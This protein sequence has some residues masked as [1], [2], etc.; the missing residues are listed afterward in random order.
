MPTVRERAAP[1]TRPEAAEDPGASAGL[2]A[3]VAWLGAWLLWAAAVV[4]LALTSQFFDE[5]LLYGVFFLAALAF[6]LVA[7][8]LLVR[9]R[10]PRAVAIAMGGQLLLIAAWIVIRAMVPLLSLEGVAEP[11]NLWGVVAMG[12]ELLSILVLAPWVQIR[13]R[14][15][16]RVRAMLAAAAGG[17]FAALFL[18]ASGA[19]SYYSPGGL[20]PSIN[21]FDTPGWQLSSPLYY[22]LIA[23]HVWLV[24]SWSV[25]SFTAS[26][27]VFVTANVAVM[28]RR[29][30]AGSVAALGRSDTAAMLPALVGVSS[31]C[32]SPLLLVFGA[33]G[34]SFLYRVTPWLLLAT[35]GLLAVNLVLQLRRDADDDPAACAWI[36][37]DQMW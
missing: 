13:A 23:P 6:Q 25:L 27:A 21:V 29:G 4:H 12:L 26:A 19:L 10:S 9:Q 20:W 1:G 14:G 34:V 22:G 24:A 11:V 3:A 31:C 15:S 5:R 37:S 2:P 18:L 17:G 36:R 32:G 28:L 16:A 33:A 8:W 30:T 35:V 7:G